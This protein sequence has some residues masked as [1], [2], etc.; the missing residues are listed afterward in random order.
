MTLYVSVDGIESDP[1]PVGSGTANERDQWIVEGEI[2]L[3]YDL[4]DDRPVDF[5]ARV[6]LA[7]GGESED[8]SGAILTGASWTLVSEGSTT[9]AVTLHGS[10]AEGAY[11]WTSEARFAVD[12]GGRVVGE[13]M[14][15]LSGTELVFSYD[16]EEIYCLVAAPVELGYVFDLTGQVQ[17]GG[18]Q[19]QAE[20][21]QAAEFTT[22]A[23]GDGA[24]E[25]E[26]EASLL[27]V[28]SATLET[29]VPFEHEERQAVEQPTSGPLTYDAV[30]VGSYEG[31]YQWVNTIR[32]EG[33]PVGAVDPDC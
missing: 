24:T 10:N 15:F 18:L 21:L 25:A 32:K 27:A 31:L 4:D 22:E 28:I 33:C 13:G 14:G 7:S 17:E 9:A 11:S 23:C 26:I 29:D 30:V 12:G 2:P 20:N 6:E 19:L 16:D 5:L 8:R 1:V 3:G